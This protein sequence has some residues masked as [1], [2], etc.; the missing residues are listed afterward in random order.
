MKLDA[1]A[2]GDVPG[3]SLGG[4]GKTPGAAAVD[5]GRSRKVVVAVGFSATRESRGTD[6][7]GRRCVHG[8]DNG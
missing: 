6:V 4:G 1:R 7:Q 5:L 3:A 8:S 2:E